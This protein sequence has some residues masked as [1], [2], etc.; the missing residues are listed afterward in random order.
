MIIVGQ[1]YAYSDR[2]L[3]IRGAAVSLVE[4]SPDDSIDSRARLLINALTTQASKTVYLP[5]AHCP[6]GQPLSSVTR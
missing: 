4:T 1:L 2:W 6:Y 3:E 5:S